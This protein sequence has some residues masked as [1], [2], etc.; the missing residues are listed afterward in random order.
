VVGVAA[1]GVVDAATVFGLAI[2]STVVA[3][4]LEFKLPSR[5]AFAAG[6]SSLADMVPASV[7]S[8]DAISTVAVMVTMAGTG[9][10]V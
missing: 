9:T 4:P 1:D 6:F 7:A 3:M 8:S 2:P 5:D 10:G